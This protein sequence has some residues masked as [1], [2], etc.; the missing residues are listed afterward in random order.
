VSR[1]TMSAPVIGGDGSD[2]PGDA[3]HRPDAPCRPQRQ[4]DSWPDFVQRFCDV[5]GSADVKVR[6]RP[7]FFL[8]AATGRAQE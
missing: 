4:C 1:S 5:Y 6:I 7:K 2:L 3:H 8:P